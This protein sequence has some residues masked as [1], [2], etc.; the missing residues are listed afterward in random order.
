MVGVRNFSELLL[1]GEHG[2]AVVYLVVERLE[3]WCRGS[4]R[5]LSEVLVADTVLVKV[6][7]NATLSFARAVQPSAR[8]VKCHRAWVA[9]NM[10]VVTWA[11]AY[12][13]K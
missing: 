6:D 9:H 7:H 12:N 10:R 8:A 13:R 2:L 1:D 3:S 5:M 11:G 4:R